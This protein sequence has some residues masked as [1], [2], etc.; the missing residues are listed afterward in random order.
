MQIHQYPSIP[1]APADADVLAI[2]VNGITYKVSKAVL[3]AAIAANISPADIGAYSKTQTYAK[4]ET[5]S[6]TETDNAIAQS[7]AYTPI[8]LTAGSGVTISLQDCYLYGKLL[9]VS[10]TWSTASSIS[11]YSNIALF[12]YAA[13]MSWSAPLIT[14][15]TVVVAN[16]GLYADKGNRTIRASTTIPAGTYKTFLIIP[17]D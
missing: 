5:Y 6:K 12:D 17:I 11:S 8:T 14:A 3:A 7:T 4:T 16:N 9:L 2:E 1:Q 10:M 13:K 15:G